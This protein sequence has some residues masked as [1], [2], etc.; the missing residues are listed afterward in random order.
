MSRR[1][2]Q[3]LY[4]SRW[5]RARKIFLASHPLCRMCERRCRVTAATVV[6]HRDPHRGDFDLFWNQDNWQALCQPCH[7]RHKQS[8]ERTG[9]LKGCDKDG[10]PLDPA[11]RW[12]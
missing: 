10:L 5:E 9:A 1:S 4:G 3:Q 7:D 6:D 2:R 12:A 11:H 8:Q